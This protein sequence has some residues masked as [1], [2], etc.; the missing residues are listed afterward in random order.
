[1]SAYACLLMKTISL[2]LGSAVGSDMGSACMDRRLVNVWG[3]MCCGVCILVDSNGRRSSMEAPDL[4]SLER[5]ACEEVAAEDLV[6]ERSYNVSMDVV[7][8]LTRSSNRPLSQATIGSFRS[9]DVFSD[10]FSPTSLFE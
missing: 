9:A 3:S 7:R 6:L 1:M 4:N 5:E 10:S 8:S 2:V